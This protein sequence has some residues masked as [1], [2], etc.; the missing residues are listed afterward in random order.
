M[1]ANTALDR[2]AAGHPRAGGAATLGTHTVSRIGYGAIQLR[3]LDRDAALTLLRR[4]VEL[5]VDHID[6]AQFYGGANEFLREALTPADGT[7]IVT[8]VGAD[9]NPGGPIPL[10]PAQRPEQLRASIEDNLESLGL[11]QLP[12]VNLRR[13]DAGPG[14]RAEGDQV[15]D[16]DDQLAVLIALREQGKIGAIGLSGVDLEGL[17]RALPADIVCV[18]NSYSLVS[19]TDE[20]LLELCTANH[21]A[22]IPFFPLGGALPGLP[23]VTDD[24]TIRSVATALGHTPSQIALAWLLHHAPNILLIPGTADRTHLEANIAVGSIVL[25]PDTLATL[26]AIPSRVAE[27]HF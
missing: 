25:D 13:L 9:P 18:Q 4:S 12:V 7:V 2:T 10:R 19:R 27:I 23:K 3:R 24:P 26:D 22:W 6:T 14:L 11:Q 5:G 21:I 20:P 17:R 8:K 15:V 1:T 16:L